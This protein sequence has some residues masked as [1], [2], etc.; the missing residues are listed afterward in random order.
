VISKSVIVFWSVACLTLFVHLV[1]K[2]EAGTI[3][4]IL[5]MAPIWAIVV[6]PT[7]VVSKVFKWRKVYSPKMRMIHGGVL[8]AI[9]LLTFMIV[10]AS[11]QPPPMKAFGKNDPRAISGRGFQ[12]FET[13][14]AR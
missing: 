4:Y 11:Q 2:H 9:G 10:N 3:Y 1:G 8:T 7:A 5:F 6:I 12:P 13:R 14:D